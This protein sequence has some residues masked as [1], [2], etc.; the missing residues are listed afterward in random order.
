MHHD[1]ETTSCVGPSKDQSTLSCLF[2]FYEVQIF[3]ILFIV[4]KNKSTLLKY[5]TGILEK[6]K[7]ITGI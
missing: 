1:S 5:I 2:T 4:R 7:S 6:R 3:I